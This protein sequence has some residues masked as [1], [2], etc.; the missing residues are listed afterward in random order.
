MKVQQKQKIIGTKG[1]IKL[2]SRFHQSQVIEIFDQHRTSIE[3]LNLPYQGNGYIHEINEV[4]SC[5]EQGKTQSE[6][7]PLEFSVNLA[8]ILE[9]VKKEIG[10][11]YK[12]G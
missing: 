9:Q 2:H 3:V 7:L 6:L 10:L 1:S 11:S 4:N 5:I 12:V 8:E